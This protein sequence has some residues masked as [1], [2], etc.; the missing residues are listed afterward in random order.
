MFDPGPKAAGPRPP[1]WKR[2]VS[3]A[4]AAS[5][6]FITDLTTQ[7]S[8]SG[9]LAVILLNALIHPRRFRWKDTMM[10][11]ER[12]G[13]NAV[14]I[15]FLVSI[16]LGL[17]LAFQSA[18]P[19]QRFGAQIYVIDI[20]AVAVTRELGPLITAILLA[21]R[22]G[23]AFAAELSTMK[24]NE[25]INALTTLGLEP[26][27][28]LVGPRVMAAVAAMPLLVLVSDF[29]AILGGGLVMKSFGFT[30]VIYLHELRQAVNLGDIL[31]GLFK[32]LFFGL[33]VAGIGCLRGF[34]AGLGAQSVG[35]S[36]TRA[37]VS[38]IVLI[39]ILDGIFSTVFYYLGI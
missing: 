20:V 37:V 3:G 18:I 35:I 31:G 19:M 1:V 8:F 5:A 29:A 14:G 4:G 30:S 32:S 10:V 25:E 9:E 33:L 21:G 23:T 16:L 34:Q 27:R 24:I 17:I 2:W 26:V 13:P 11:L 22:S 7:I 12:A 38:G 36:A 28:F 6:H 39:L 15:V